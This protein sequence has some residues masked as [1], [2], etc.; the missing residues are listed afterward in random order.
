M[1]T[2]TVRA[3]A[4]L[5]ISASVPASATILFNNFADPSVGNRSAFSVSQFQSFSTGVGGFSL[6]DVQLLLE[7][8]SLSDAASFSV[9]LYA[10]SSTS[11]GSLISSLGT[12]NDSAVSNV[13]FTATD[14]SFSAISLSANTRYW[15]G[16]TSSNGSNTRWSLGEGPQPGDVGVSG[17]FYDDS[18]SISSTTFLTT[19]FVSFQMQLSD[20]PA[21]PEPATMVLAMA[22]LGAVALLRRRRR[23]ELL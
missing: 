22:G 20:G 6:G 9:G 14:F 4:L 5:A 7:G 18:G 13:G 2:I 8:P 11:P 16:L 15:I 21:V 1:K 3:L 10:D 23:S 19:Q 12:M 17:E